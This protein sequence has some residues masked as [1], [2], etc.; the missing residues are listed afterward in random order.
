MYILGA[1]VIINCLC[2]IRAELYTAITDLED[3]LDTE[4]MFMETL[5]RYI[6]REEKKLER[7]KRK[8]EEYKKEHSLASADVSE[9]LSN[10][11]NA[12]LLV[13]RLTTD[14]TTTESLMTDQTAL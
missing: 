14:W 8:A 10:P 1:W 13:K 5:N 9:Y 11:I 12:Y 3:L 4:A 2:L 6:Q 7:L